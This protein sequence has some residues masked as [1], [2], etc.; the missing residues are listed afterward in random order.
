MISLKI[1]LASEGSLCS[2]VDLKSIHG[3]G[4]DSCGIVCVYVRVSFL[5]VCCFLRQRFFTGLEG[6]A[7]LTVWSVSC[8]D[9]S[10]SGPLVLGLQAYATMSGSQT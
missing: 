5:S 7:R 9:L 6:R 1:L 3:V 8:R 10:V 2:A 4:A